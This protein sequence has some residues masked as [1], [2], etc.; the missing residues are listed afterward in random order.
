M[1][2]VSQKVPFGINEILPLSGF[3]KGKIRICQRNDEFTSIFIRTP[4]RFI[5]TFPV[6]QSGRWHY[7]P[8]LNQGVN[9]RMA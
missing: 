8:D 4:R 6:I 7:C 1:K 5:K 9:A 2:F 3:P